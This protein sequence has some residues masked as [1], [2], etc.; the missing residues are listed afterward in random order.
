MLQHSPLLSES[1]R[2]CRESL[3]R[4]L[5]LSMGIYGLFLPGM[6]R[7]I[8]YPCKGGAGRCGGSPLPWDGSGGRGGMG[9]KLGN[10]AH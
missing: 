10:C 5:G 8:V 9:N 7:Y 1:L 6:S 3:A 4:Y 2:F